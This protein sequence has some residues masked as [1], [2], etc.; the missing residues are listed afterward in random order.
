[1]T[2]LS[3][4]P[5]PRIV[6]GRGADLALREQASYPASGLHSNTSGFFTISGWEICP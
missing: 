4:P 1:M 5:D 3:K 2:Y 6:D